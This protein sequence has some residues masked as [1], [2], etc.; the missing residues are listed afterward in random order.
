M[1]FN[2]NS[3]PLALL[4]ALIL[5]SAA[6]A[7][8][9]RT[10]GRT[11][12]RPPQTRPAPSPSPSTTA[13]P[14]T[15]RALSNNDV[16]RMVRGNFSE[17]TIIAAIGA[18]E[19]NFDVSVDALLQLRDAGVS[20]SI[21]DTML[22]ATAQ[23]RGT[24]QTPASTTPPPVAPTNTGA[25]SPAASNDT[26]RPYPLPPDRGAYLWDGTTLHLLQQS[27]V[28]S[29]GTNFWRRMTPFVRNRIE[30][31]LIGARARVQ[32]TNR[33]PTILLS[34]LGDVIPGV[35]SYRWLYVRTGG[36]RRDRRIV[37]T[38]DIGGFFGSVRMVD[39]EIECE[40]TR[41]ADGVYA[42][43]PVRPLADGEYGLTQVP[44]LADAQAARS[45]ALPVW[46]FGIYAN[47]Q[48]AQATPS[49]TP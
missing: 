22:A 49:P 30:L 34:G 35:P 23:R 12:P 36:M 19:T 33:Q 29:M 45:F 9:R 27:P 16:I 1:F 46:D 21:I 43:T 31:Q 7:Q 6:V 20:Q 28:P 8:T 18:N 47:S 3:L 38:Y 32:F 4:C 13:A 42:I 40:I 2:R 44:R 15:R 39:N 25:T 41:V 48:P 26:T 10:P 5:T 11:T 37:G 14:Q 17:Q 24:S